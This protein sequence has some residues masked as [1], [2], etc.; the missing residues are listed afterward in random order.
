MSHY[1]AIRYTSIPSLMQSHHLILAYR[2]ITAMCLMFLIFKMMPTS[3][4]RNNPLQLY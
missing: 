2:R 3:N 1:L 4:G